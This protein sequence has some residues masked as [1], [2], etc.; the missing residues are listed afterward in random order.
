MQSAFSLPHHS[1]RLFVEMHQLWAMIF[2]YFLSANCITMQMQ[3]SSTHG[4]EA[5]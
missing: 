4:Q 2:S 3:A 1:V 5:R